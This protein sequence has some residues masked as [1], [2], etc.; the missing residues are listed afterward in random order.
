ML[1]DFFSRKGLYLCAVMI[2]KAIHIFLA[3]IV[4]LSSIGVTL[5]MHFCKGELKNVSLITKAEECNKKDCT[6]HK[7]KDYSLLGI[8]TD[9]LPKSCCEKADQDTQAKGCCDDRTEYLSLDSEF[10]TPDIVT[11]YDVLP[12]LLVLYPELFSSLNSAITSGAQWS[13]LHFHPPLLTKDIPIL[14]QSFLI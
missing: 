13:F 8:N 1:I 5:N 4:Y 10:T 12:V 6:A 11:L 9:Q 14:V 2:P 7:E 3:I